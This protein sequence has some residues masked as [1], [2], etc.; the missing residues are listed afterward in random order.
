MPSC[1]DWQAKDSKILLDFNFD[2]FDTNHLSFVMDF[3]S[4]EHNKEKYVY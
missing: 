4:K 3:K 2:F 1:C